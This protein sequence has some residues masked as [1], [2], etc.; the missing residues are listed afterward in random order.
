[1]PMFRCLPVGRTILT[2]FQAQ[3][4][5]Q[6]INAPPPGRPNAHVIGTEASGAPEVTAQKSLGLGDYLGK[7]SDLIGGIYGAGGPGDALIALG[8]LIGLME[9][10][11]RP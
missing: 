8:C 1:M 3:A 11:F 5:P 6:D 10:P 4:D 7:A 2:S 9:H